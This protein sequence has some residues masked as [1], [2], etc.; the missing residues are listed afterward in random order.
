MTVLPPDINKS[1]NEFEIENGQSI[2]FG[3]SAIKNVG[4]AAIGSILKERTIKP[5]RNLEDFCSRVDL[6]AVNKKTVE[7]L[8]KAGAMDAFRQKS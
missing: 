5:F 4:E 1:G 8:I 3:L 6:G 2:R 7:S